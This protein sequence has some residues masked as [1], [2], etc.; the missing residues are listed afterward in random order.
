MKKFLQI[1]LVLA[2]AISSFGTNVLA[3]ESFED[4]VEH[5][6]ID[7]EEKKF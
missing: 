2:I 4:E 6:V 7:M 3:K 5:I 1:M